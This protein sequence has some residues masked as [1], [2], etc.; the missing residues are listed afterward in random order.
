MTQQILDGDQVGAARPLGELLEA[1]IQLLT[2]YVVFRTPAQPLVIALWIAH[3]HALAAFDVTPYLHVQSPQKRSAKT[4]L[5]ELLERLVARPWRVVEATAPSVFRK[6]KRD[7]PTILL[8]EVDAIFKSKA[9]ETAEALRGVLNA[10]YRR[11]ACVPRCT[12]K[13][14]EQLEDFPVFGAKALAGIGRIPDTV[15]DRSIPITLVR[16]KKSERV[17]RF[18]FRAVKQETVLLQRALATWA[19]AAVAILREAR[20]ALPDKL[21]DRAAEIAEPLLAIA[22]AAGGDWSVPA[23]EAVVFLQESGAEDA[24]SVGVLLLAAIKDIFKEAK[25]DQ[26]LTVDLLTHLVERESEPWPGWWGQD[27]DK[28]AKDGVTPKKPSMDL[29]RHL[30]GFD[31]KPKKLRI[32]KRTWNGYELADFADAFARYLGTGDEAEG[33][34][35]EAETEVPGDEAE[36]AQSAENPPKGRNVGTTHA[37]QG[38]EAF[39]PTSDGQEVGTPETLAAQGLFR[40]SDLWGGTEGDF[41]LE[42]GDRE[43]G[44][45]DGDDDD[46]ECLG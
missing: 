34:E 40:R 2:R 7:E 24:E 41:G 18:R 6:I 23:R 46:G 4:R 15:A 37:A 13:N 39:R 30:R 21:D 8:D 9:S 3:T 10:G 29:A 45:D 11:G 26:L 1:V 25:A 33:A 19:K 17:A 35:N 28:A 43:P 44:E 5:L 12:G 20:P 31:V 32:G 36:R 16:K 42:G 22:D 38:F 14:F 27:V